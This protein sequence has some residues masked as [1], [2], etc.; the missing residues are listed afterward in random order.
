MVLGALWGMWG[1][2]QAIDSGEQATTAAFAWYAGVA[3]IVLAC[4]LL[5]WLRWRSPRLVSRAAL[6]ISMSLIGLLAL[7]RVIQAP[8]TAL[9]L[10]PLLAA[11]V[12]ALRRLPRGSLLVITEPAPGGPAVLTG[13]TA[14]VAA[15]IG[16]YALMQATAVPAAY[17]PAVYIVTTT[18]GFALFLRATWLALR[19]RAESA[20]VS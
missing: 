9:V 14:M 7:V 6:I 16:A 15:A 4:G 1:G 18:A 2:W 20:A 17:G 11:A 19:R 8:W 3:G 12:W 10:G 5:G 13:T